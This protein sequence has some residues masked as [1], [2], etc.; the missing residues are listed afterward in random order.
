MGEPDGKVYQI[1]ADNLDRLKDEI[2]R[3]SYL[4]QQAGEAAGAM[5]SGLSKQWD[6]AVTQEML[7]AYGDAVKDAMRKI[8]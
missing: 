8:L 5:Q 2:Y 7:G 3:V 6:F 4:M 1:A